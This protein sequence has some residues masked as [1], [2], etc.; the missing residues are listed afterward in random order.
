VVELR[1]T[2]HHY[3]ASEG[4]ILHLGE[5]TREAIEE[6]REARVAP[7]AVIDRGQLVRALL[8]NE[9]G[10]KRVWAPL[11]LVDTAFVDALKGGQGA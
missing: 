8:A 10:V 1:G 4:V 9:I 5:A 2:L 11:T 3:S 6:S 7:I